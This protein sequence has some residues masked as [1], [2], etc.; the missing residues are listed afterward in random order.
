MIALDSSAVV[1]IALSEPEEP[2]FSRA[3]AI[4]HAIVG[5]PTM[6][7]VCMV[8]GPRLSHAAG[9]FL[10]DLGNR[11]SVTIVAFDAAMYELARAAF[12]LFGKGSGHPAQLNFGDC[13]SYA[14]AKAHGVPLLFKGNDFI[15]T[16]IEPAYKPIP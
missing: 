16:D 13:M 12:A 7:E 15:H 3:I 11:P 1:A 8:L 10:T 2:A 14:V 5:A 4:E 6:V 9:K